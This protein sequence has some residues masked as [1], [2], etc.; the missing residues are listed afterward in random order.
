MLNSTIK[1]DNPYCYKDNAESQYISMPVSWIVK[2]IYMTVQN[3][4][5]NAEVLEKFD[6]V[7]A[8]KLTGVLQIY[9]KVNN[10]GL[11]SDLYT[12][13]GV[14]IKD[15]KPRI[16]HTIGQVSFNDGDK[17]K[18]WDLYAKFNDYDDFIEDHNANIIKEMDS[19][20]KV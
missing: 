18:I 17:R 6:K 10:I 1:D 9:L 20:L 3:A 2:D 12:N 13:I 14:G 11:F 4:R 7:P 16:L 8:D 19:L 15:L 5:T